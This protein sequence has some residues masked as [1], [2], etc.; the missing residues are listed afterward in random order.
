M[1]GSGRKRTKKK[2]AENDLDRKIDI[3]PKTPYPEDGTKDQ[4]NSDN[5]Q[6]L[7]EESRE[8]AARRSESFMDM[9]G[10]LEVSL[11]DRNETQP[12]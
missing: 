8:E 1:G 5:R 12:Q 2:G 10:Y 4:M 9:E 11:L 6:K 3:P 7:R